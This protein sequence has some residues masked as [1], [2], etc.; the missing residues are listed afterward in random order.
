MFG[1][2]VGAISGAF[3]GVVQCMGLEQ[4]RITRTDWYWWILATAVGFAG[5]F[6]I[7]YPIGFL[8]NIDGTTLSDML[9]DLDNYETFL[10]IVGAVFGFVLSIP[11]WQMLQQ[12]TNRAALWILATTLGFGAMFA[13]SNGSE[14]IFF[15]YTV[16]FFVL[17]GCLLEWLLRTQRKV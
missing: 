1:A 11:Q 12:H 3:L 13:F 7:L 15:G 16:L 4:H 2:L 9:R 14:Y 5:G 8:A 17:L 6:A 10:F